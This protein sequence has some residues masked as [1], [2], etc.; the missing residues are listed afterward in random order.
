MRKGQ[1]EEKL[2]NVNNFIKR[3]FECKKKKKGGD[4]RRAPILI[5]KHLKSKEMSPPVEKNKENF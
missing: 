1:H 5:Y 2:E 3:K 4:N